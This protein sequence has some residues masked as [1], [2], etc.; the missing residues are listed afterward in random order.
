MHGQHKARHLCN[1]KFSMGTHKELQKQTLFLVIDVQIRTNLHDF[2]TTKAEKCASNST[3]TFGQTTQRCVSV[4]WKKQRNKQIARQKI[5]E[6]S[7]SRDH[8][9]INY[10][11]EE[12]QHLCL[13]VCWKY[14][15]KLQS[16]FWQ[17]QK[18]SLG[19]ISRHTT[20]WGAANIHTHATTKQDH[21]LLTRPKQKYIHNP[22]L[23][24]HQS[25]DRRQDLPAF[26]Q[27]RN[28]F[29]SLCLLP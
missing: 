28:H 12:I 7:G 14:Q 21:A 9:N 8:K 3:G 10:N 1:A 25:T 24:V 22:R 17:Q 5:P 29:L 19:S 2:E 4:K 16:H 13:F 23:W 27:N 6:S 11:N 20:T 18:K 26:S 15:S